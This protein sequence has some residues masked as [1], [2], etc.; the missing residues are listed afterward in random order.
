M[1]LLLHRCNAC[2]PGPGR[3]RSNHVYSRSR[4]RRLCCTGNSGIVLSWGHMTLGPGCRCC[5]CTGTGGT[6]RLGAQC[7]HSNQ[8][9]SVHSESLY[10]PVYSCRGSDWMR[11]QCDRSPHW[12]VHFLGSQDRDMVDSDLQTPALGSQRNPS[13]TFH[14]TVHQCSLCSSGTPLSAGCSHQCD[15]YTGMACS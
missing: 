13:H 5:H 14:S 6:A 11:C 12:S 1:Y 3:C 9:H 4:R 7:C 10:I 15:R 8:G 2:S